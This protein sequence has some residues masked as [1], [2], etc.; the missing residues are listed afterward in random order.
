MPIHEYAFGS[1]PLLLGCAVKV[2]DFLRALLLCAFPVSALLVAGTAAAWAQ[3]RLTGRVSLFIHVFDLQREYVIA[4]WIESLLFVLCALVF[5]LLGWSP[6][7]KTALNPLRRFIYRCFAFGFFVLA[8]DEMLMLHERVGE[9]L[10]KMTGFLKDTPAEGT[11]FAWMIFYGP[12]AVAVVAAMLWAS[13]GLLRR[14]PLRD[15]VRRGTRALGAAVAMVAVAFA[16]EAAAAYLAAHGTWN[17]PLP[18]FEES[19]ELAALLS[20]AWAHLEIAFGYEL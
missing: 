8:G 13:V 5:V 10:Q 6:A 11:P 2:R 20:F 4:T 17:T 14:C 3:E 19:A 1:V 18:V 12:A 16:A 9:A 15:A 7:S